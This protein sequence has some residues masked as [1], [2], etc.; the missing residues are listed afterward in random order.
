MTSPTNVPPRAIDLDRTVKLEGTERHVLKQGGSQYVEY[1]CSLLLV[2]LHLLALR[3]PPKPRSRMPRRPAL[4]VSSRPMPRR[5]LRV[6][7]SARQSPKGSRLATLQEGRHFTVMRS[8]GPLRQRRL[9]KTGAAKK[10]RNG[11][12]SQGRPSGRTRL[13]SASREADAAREPCIDSDDQ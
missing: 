13:C 1:L 3:S 11:A 8:C 2:S 6:M 9:R 12:L 5:R 7:F 10:C 4:H